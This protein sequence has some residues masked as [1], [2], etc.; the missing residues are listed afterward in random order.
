VL[1]TYGDMVTQPG[2]LPLITLHKLLL[3]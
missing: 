2:E 3:S 1:I